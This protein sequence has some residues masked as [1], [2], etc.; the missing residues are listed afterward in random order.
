VLNIS[1][2]R[3]ITPANGFD[4]DVN[5]AMQNNYAWSM[6][7]MEE[8]LYVGTGRNILYNVLLAIK[9]SGLIGDFEIPKELTPKNVDNRAEI[10]RYNK[11]LPN[12]GWQKV[13]KAP[14]DLNLITGFRYMVRY[15]DLN[16]QTALYVGGYC[17]GKVRT[18][19]STDG[20]NWREIPNDNLN[21]TSTRAMVIHTNKKLYMSTV[22]EINPLQPA[23]IYEYIPP[24]VQMPQGR[25]EEVTGDPSDP[26]FKPGKNPNTQVMMMASFKDHIYAATI[27]VTEGFELWK[28]EGTEPKINEWKLVIDKGAGDALNII[29]L[30]LGVFKEYLYIGAIMF[31]LLAQNSMDFSSFKAFDVVRID[32]RDNWQL[33][34]GGRPKKP[35]NPTTGTRGKALS[36]KTSG[37]GNPF[38][39]YCWQLEEYNGEFFLGTF[40]WSVLLRPLVPAIIPAFLNLPE[41]LEELEKLLRI[42]LSILL[43]AG[44]AIY[45]FEGFDLYKSKDGIHWL[46]I[47]LTGLRDPHNYGAR[48]LFKSINGHLYLGTANPFDGCEVWEK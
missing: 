37:L 47:T 16:G 6:A 7:E 32:E 10:W 11:I 21:G 30:T 46:P 9:N 48:L 4:T 35:T 28:T 31:P 42:I 26:G 39:L 18:F 3:K 24:T 25:W 5:N 44:A 22:D 34:I 27:N 13:F 36:P 14:D 33:V 19:R 45:P 41:F 29:P 38:N 17:Q 2:F 23:L 40:D 1:G 12:F 43:T 20:L 15:T 8:H